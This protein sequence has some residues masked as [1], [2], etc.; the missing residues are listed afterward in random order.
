MGG[1]VS[2][3]MPRWRLPTVV[4]A[5]AAALALL[6]AAGV[7]N[8]APV[9]SL[10]IAPA[11]VS[12]SSPIA[13]FS[14]D[15]SGTYEL[16]RD[17]AADCVSG[18]VL[19]S[20]DYTA[21][22][23]VSVPILAA[24]LA[25]G[26]NTLR[27][28]INSPVEGLGSSTAVVT[29]DTVPPA[30]PSLTVRP[31]STSASASARFE[32]THLEPSIS[33]VC[34]LDAQPAT[35]CT[36][37]VQL[38]G[39]ADGS[40]TFS[41]YAIDAA[42]NAGSATPAVVTWL[43]DTSNPQTILDR[44]PAVDANSTTATF[45]FS[46]PAASA[47]FECSLDGGPQLGPTFAPCTSPVTYTGLSDDTHVFTVR[48][49]SRAG[50][51]DRTPAAW[52]WTVD[53][54]APDTVLVGAPMGT[55]QG[56]DA[57]IEFATSE[58]GAGFE[59]A[60]NGGPYVICKS[61]HVYAGLADGPYSVSVRAVDAAGNRDRSPV[62]ASFA[63]DAPPE[64]T[65]VAGPVGAIATREATFVF[66]SS[67]ASDSFECSLDGAGFE[68]CAS[69]H[70]LTGLA[71]GE[72][73]LEV[74]ALDVGGE[75]DP[76]PARAVWSVVTLAAS[77]AKFAANVR[78]ARVRTG[79]G[80]VLLSWRRPKD[81][82]YHHVEIVRLPGT[83][84]KARSMIYRGNKI[85]RFDKG[86][87]AGVEYTWI[88]YAVDKKGNRSGGVKVKVTLPV[89]IV[90]GRKATLEPQTPIILSWSVRKK[91]QFYNVQLFRGKTKVLSS[92]PTKPQVS[93][94]GPWNW[95]GTK[96]KLVAGTYQWFVWPGFGKRSESKFGKMIGSG[97][98]VVGKPKQAPKKTPK[99]KSKKKKN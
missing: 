49:I 62:A 77:P 31:M 1:L 25:E 61:P 50:V 84:K 88:I 42:G 41:I 30:S 89:R 18:T 56:R 35:S 37:P 33:Y 14:A 45:A 47:T 23:E 90:L 70:T 60:L 53:T 34:R 93:L 78:K 57:V 67:T 69:P 40:H 97:K 76:T 9:V 54:V 32:F 27:A 2:I 52:V 59:C 11:L 92:W 72:H 17:A 91:A 79:D 20:G 66:G 95:E 6:G 12:T 80:R 4:A 36:S 24:L 63:V 38:T 26:P 19:A 28:C 86:L 39:L 87:K 58:V 21:P 46:S 83:G 51:R 44:T 71:T 48:A 15:Q 7:A 55:I 75:R 8:A 64:T 74:R 81:R 3:A 94:T 65:V 10:E 22:V 43:I 98:L 29:K 5:L 96:R 85:R 68:P 16:R 99:K 73:T 82:D 13:T